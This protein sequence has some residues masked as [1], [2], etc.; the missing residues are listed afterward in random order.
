MFPMTSGTQQTTDDLS[1]LEGKL[2]GRY[3]ALMGSAALAEALGFASVNTFRQA[4]WRTKIDIP[5]FN[6]PGRAG[7]FAITY[8]VARWLWALR[9]SERGAQ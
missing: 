6:V 7:R 4:C 8:D 9:E 1:E 2:V 5:M 3:G